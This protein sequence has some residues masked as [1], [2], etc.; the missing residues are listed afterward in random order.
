[1]QY[2]R[3]PK[4]KMMGEITCAGCGKI[5]PH[6]AKGKCIKCYDKMPRR[7]ITCISCGERKS[8]EARQLCFT[9]YRKSRN[10]HPL[11]KASLACVKSEEENKR[12]ALRV[13]PLYP[14]LARPG[15]EEKILVFIARHA[16]FETLYHP[17]DCIIPKEVNGAGSKRIDGGWHNGPI[18]IYGTPDVDDD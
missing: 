11:L 5:K 17:H 18:T 2:H 12:D 8:H 7:I 4:A 9:C 10:D 3:Q 15:S 13:L 1:M 16:R 6:R 14:T